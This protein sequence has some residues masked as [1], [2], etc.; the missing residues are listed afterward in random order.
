MAQNYASLAGKVK[1]SRSKTRTSQQKPIPGRED[2]MVENPAGGYSFEADS[3]ARLDRFLVLGVSGNSIYQSQGDLVKENA[4]LID[5]LLNEDGLRVVETA[6]TILRE[7]RSFKVDAPFFVL[8][9]AASHADDKVR[10]R[11]L[12]VVPEVVRTPTHL[13][14]FVDYV[15][16]MRGWGRA[17][18]R[19]VGRYYTD[20]AIPKLAMHSWKYKSRDGWSH[21]DLLRLAHAETNDP[22]RNAVLR[23]MARGDLPV[24]F[25]GD[26]ALEQIMAAEELLHTKEP[27]DAVRLIRDHRLTREAVPTELLNDRKVWDALIED[28]PMVATIR[29]LGKMSSLGMTKGLSDV[30]KQIVDRITD[31]DQI[32]RSGIH[33][34]QILIAMK[35]YEKGHGIRGSL[36]WSVNRN[37]ADA[38]DEAFYMAIGNV[39]PTGKRILLAGDDSGSMTSSWGGSVMSGIMT[40]AEAAAAMMLVTYMVE[41]NA[42]MIGYS[43]DYKDIPASRRTTINSLLKHFGRGGGTNTALPV[44]YALD[45][46]IDF[47]AI[48]SY[49]DNCTWAGYGSY[50]GWGGRRGRAGHVTEVL[51]DYQNKVGHPVRFAN[52]SMEANRISDVD[53]SNPN[54]FEIAGL[55]ANTPKIIGEFVAGRI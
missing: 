53:P 23:Y 47:D 19:S 48:V 35:T 25:D 54:M 30:E 24:D 10:A 28:M 39:E 13:Y 6:A 22:A 42:V 3:W 4:S 45:K 36:S 55:D 1:P 33:P 38:L 14:T 26:V 16:S 27:K 40:A 41:K 5:T 31:K 46:N 44:H 12:A 29:N 20:T 18:R 50:Y 34:M 32:E 21:R 15:N 7:G 49:T 37:I 43:T 17:L 2:E 51:R 52:C 9:M 11:A 8:A